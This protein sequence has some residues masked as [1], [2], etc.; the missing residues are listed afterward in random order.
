MKKCSLVFLFCLSVICGIGQT[1]SSIELKTKKSVR[2]W[3][4][5]C[6]LDTDMEK[7]LYPLLLAKQKEIAIAHKKYK[8]KEVTIKA[9]ERE[10]GKKYHGKLKAILG[11]E[12]L[13]KMNDYWKE[14]KN[15]N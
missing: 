13:V 15:N 2:E 10:I 9:A 6:E 7:A 12:N 3:A 4:E 11:Y 8:G 5:V 1:V 14:K